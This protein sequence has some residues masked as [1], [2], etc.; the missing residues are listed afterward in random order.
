MRQRITFSE[1]LDLFMNAPLETLRQRAMEC[2]YD[3][4][5][6]NTITYVL[7]TN[8][9]Y[10][11]VCNV[12][13][14][15]CAFW[16]TPTA[17][18][19]YTETVEEALLHLAKARELG[20]T[21]VLLQG[22]LNPMLNLDYYVT[23]VRRARREYPDIH[24]HFFTASEVE[25][26]A[27]MSH[28][29]TK[30]ALQALYDAGQRTLPGGG[31]EIL[32]E[33]VHAAISPKKITPQTW[34]DIHNMA[35]DIGFCSTATMMYGHVETP[36]DVV[37]HLDR[38][39]RAQDEHPGF[40]AFVPWSY[41][42]DNTALAKKLS[43]RAGRDEYLR[44]LAF[45]RLYLDNFPHVQATWFSEGKDIGIDSLQYGADDFGGTVSEENVHR[46]ANH[47]NKTDS[48]GIQA[49]IREAGFRPVERNPLYQLSASGCSRS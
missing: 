48:E 40:T 13:C 4:N 10:T 7:D 24:P 28:V 31:A 34:V 19:A 2:R 35:H 36:E 44:M 46:A 17:C 39:R 20:L 6:A 42:K 5:P 29:S 21:T 38:I 1:G 11:N 8:P 47:I 30:E 22:G 27:R 9:N 33:R 3:K 26:A 49:M 37:L 43:H 23:L 14:S 18:D 45:S 32:S 25:H 16:R 15:F 12:C 41:K